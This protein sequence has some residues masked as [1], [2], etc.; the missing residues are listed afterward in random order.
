MWPLL[1]RLRDYRGRGGGK[2]LGGSGR[3]R[4]KWIWLVGVSGPLYSWI[5]VVIV[6]TRLHKSKP[7]NSHMDG[8]GSGAPSLKEGLWTVGDFWR[9][10]SLFFFKGLVLSR[11]TVFQWMAPHSWKY[12]QYKLDLV[13]YE[14]KEKE[15]MKLGRRET[16]GG[17]GER[18]KVT[19]IKA[20]C[21]H[22]WNSQR[23]NT[24]IGKI[25]VCAI[26]KEEPEAK[27]RSLGWGQ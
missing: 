22:I 12:G 11:S 27:L 17:V 9:K 3:R 14:E 21:T 20:H 15:D 13:S 7:V 25:N 24:Y 4:K 19:M 23:I 18:W 5:P 10:E 1:P 16:S 8:R 26:E 6:C 2:A